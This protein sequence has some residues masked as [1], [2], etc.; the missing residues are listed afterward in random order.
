MLAHT[1]EKHAAALAETLTAAIR[2]AAAH[3]PGGTADE[4]IGQALAAAPAAAYPRALTGVGTAPVIVAVSLGPHEALLAFDGVT[5]CGPAG[6][7][8]AGVLKRVI[9]TTKVWQLRGGPVGGAFWAF[10]DAA[11]NALHR[12]V[13]SSVGRVD[14]PC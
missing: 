14:L 2:A 7:R 10:S 11:A 5:V 13:T 8:L 9:E 3:A 12:L 1:A 6:R 4:I